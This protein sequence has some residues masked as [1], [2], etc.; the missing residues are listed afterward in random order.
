MSYS[1]W[2]LTKE[3]QRKLIKLYPPTYNF[4]GDHITYQFPDD[5][6]PPI[7]NDVKVISLYRDDSL[8]AFVV[9]VDGTTKRPDGSIYHITWSKLPHRKA[10]ESNELI[11]DNLNLVEVFETPVDISVT[12]ELFKTF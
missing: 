1:G 5:K 11:K 8:E 9:S 6:S 2:K 4:V 3:S 10:K 7:V 12:A